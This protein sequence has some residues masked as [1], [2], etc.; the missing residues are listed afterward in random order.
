MAALGLV[1]LVNFGFRLSNPWQ[2]LTIASAILGLFLHH[3]SA[4]TSPITSAVA[5]LLP[6]APKAVVNRV[7]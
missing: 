1:E 5:I 4:N 7:R 3:I 6:P 2:R